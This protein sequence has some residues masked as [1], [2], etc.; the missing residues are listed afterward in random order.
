[1]HVY[2]SYLFHGLESKGFPVE[3]RIRFKP[4]SM[5]SIVQPINPY[6][7]YFYLPSTT[8]ITIHPSKQSAIFKYESFSLAV[9]CLSF[10]SLCEMQ[11]S[12]HKQ[13]AF[14]SLIKKF[15]SNLLFLR[16]GS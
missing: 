6:N 4:S 5:L 9:F 2:N 12:E 8:N 7:E 13:F 15:E 14:W 1:M 10:E 16:F 11:C 3:S